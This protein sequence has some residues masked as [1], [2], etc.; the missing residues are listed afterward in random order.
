[1]T[2]LTHGSCNPYSINIFCSVS[3]LLSSTIFPIVVI[4]A[5]LCHAKTLK[6]KM[7]SQHA[8]HFFVLILNVF[9]FFLLSITLWFLFPDYLISSLFNLSFFT[10]VDITIFIHSRTR[11]TRAEK[12]CIALFLIL[13]ILH[14]DGITQLYIFWD[15]I[16]NQIDT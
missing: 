12:W 9:S 1:M 11:S 4:T 3:S 6:S 10:P 14:T 8:I 7:L 15:A 5:T 13:Q 16:I 2:C